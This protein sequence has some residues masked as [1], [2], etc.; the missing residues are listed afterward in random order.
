LILSKNSG[1]HTQG[2]TMLQT[3]EATLEPSGQL[4]FTDLAMPVYQH[5]QKVLVTVVSPFQ[6]ASADAPAAAGTPRHDW[7]AF[8]GVLKNSPSFTGDP[9]A[10]QKQLRSEWR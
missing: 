4:F 10:I 5:A 3:Y 6:S 2:Q 7:R 1:S 9:L 8:A